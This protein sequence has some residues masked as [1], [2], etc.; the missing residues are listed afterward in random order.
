MQDSHSCEPGSIPGRRMTV[1]TPFSI[2]REPE[3]LFPIVFQGIA[4]VPH[5]IV[6]D[7]RICHLAKGLQM[8]GFRK[9]ICLRDCKKNGCKKIYKVQKFKQPLTRN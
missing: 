2:I 6:D 8:S 3:M 1:S 4:R 9:C 5:F 7:K